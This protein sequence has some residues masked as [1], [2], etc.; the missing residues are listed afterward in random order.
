LI[1]WKPEVRTDDRLRSAEMTAQGSPPPR[2]ESGPNRRGL[3][4]TKIATLVVVA[5][6]SGALSWAGWS[7]YYGQL[8]DLNW[9]PGLTLAGLAIVE[10][11]AA[12]NTRQRIERRPGR[13]RL[14]PLLVARYAVLAKASSMA[15]A[16]FA[17][18]YAGVGIWAFV[19]HGQ[20]R[21]A[22]R[23]LPPAVAGLIG[24]LALVAGAIVLERAC[25]VPPSKD[26]EAKGQGGGGTSQ[27][28]R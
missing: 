4:P 24:A 3:L 16:I 28:R 22:D 25:R 20:L 10:F 5:A 11:V 8:P 12:H 13:G 7:R 14:N 19:Q 27:Q 15:G 9:L 1:R 21:V 17:G 23:N 6:A 26:D 18:V 2:N